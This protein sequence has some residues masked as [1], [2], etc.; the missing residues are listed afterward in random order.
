MELLN[1][2]K[3]KRVSTIALTDEELVYLHSVVGG[4][5][6]TFHKQDANIIGIDEK[7]LIELAAKL[8]KVLTTTSQMLGLKVRKWDEL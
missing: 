5:R 4:V 2:D 7:H 3:E 8:N 6:S 1:Y